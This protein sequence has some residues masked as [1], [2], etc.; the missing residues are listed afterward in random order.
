MPALSNRRSA[1]ILAAIYI[2]LIIGVSFFAAPI[3]FTAEGVGLNQ[4][5]AVGKVTFQAFTW[6]ELVAY[7][8][9]VAVT[10]RVRN[11][12]VLL[13]MVVLLLLLLVQK[14]GVLPVLDVA[15]D[16]TVAGEAEGDSSLHT[17][18]VVLEV[19]K[20]AVLFYLI[21]IL[22]DDNTSTSSQGQS[23]GDPR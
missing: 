1:S 20:I 21:I 7:C 4:L 2:G 11:S 8:L 13:S 18:Y 17:V 16:R 5:L 12:K 23:F 19:L 22:G 10:W 6:I 14:L 15:L 9:L 3:K